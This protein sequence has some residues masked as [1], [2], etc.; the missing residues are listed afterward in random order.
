[1]ATK[2]PTEFHNYWGSVADPTELPNVSGATIQDS[3]V[4]VGDVCFSVSDAATY[5][6]TTA[7]PGS[8][9]WVLSS[10]LWQRSGTTL[11]PLTAG[12]SAEVHSLGLSDGAYDDPSIYRSGDPNTGFYFSGSDNVYV[13]AGGSVWCWSSTAF[14]SESIASGAPR[15]YGGG[16]GTVSNPTYNFTT[17]TTTGLYSSDGTSLEVAVSGNKRLDIGAELVYQKDALTDSVDFVIYNEAQNDDWAFGSVIFRGPNAAATPVDKD[18][19]TLY[20]VCARTVDADEDGE[21]IVNVLNAGSAQDVLSVRDNQFEVKTSETHAFIDFIE[22]AALATPTGIFTM[23]FRGKNSSAGTENYARISVVAEDDTAPNEYGSLAIETIENGSVTTAQEFA[24][25]G[26]S[27]DGY[28]VASTACVTAGTSPGELKIYHTDSTTTGDRTGDTSY[29]TFVGYS[30]TTPNAVDYARLVGYASDDTEGAEDG[31]IQFDVSYNGALVQAWTLDYGYFTSVTAYGAHLKRSVGSVAYPV[32]TFTSDTDTGIY[33]I[34]ADNLGVATG[35]SH[36]AIDANSS[37]TL[38]DPG[39][40]QTRQTVTSSSNQV[41]VD[42]ANGFIVYHDLT[43]TTAIQPPTNE[44]AN[45]ELIFLID[46]D[47]SSTISFT[48]GATA[49]GFWAES[50]MPSLG[51]SERLTIKFIY[52]TSED[53]WIESGRTVVDMSVS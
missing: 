51:A 47:G 38:F 8:G 10:S 23:R 32:F 42:C 36:L 18:Y 14:F 20:G 31:R 26:L 44:V 48:S 28:R 2:S 3:S 7:T 46:G 21:F 6:C 25:G 39:I 24:R 43:E 1:M 41:N 50:S 45:A 30:D 5:T 37:R 35:S 22:S 19:V 15:M 13:T 27:V 9:A 17:Y 11:S 16:S 29:L 53:A 49:G 33:R 52:D 4:E 12:D 34:G 40:V